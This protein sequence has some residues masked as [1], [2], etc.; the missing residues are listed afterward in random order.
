MGAADGESLV[1]S[2]LRGVDSHGVQLAP[3]YLAQLVKGRVDADACGR[4]ASEAGAV[5]CYDGQNG[6]GQVVASQA[7][8]ARGASSA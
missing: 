2:N 7:T 5:M 3:F 8:A 4:V 6:L 1:A